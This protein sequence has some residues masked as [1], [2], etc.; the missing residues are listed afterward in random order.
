MILVLLHLYARTVIFFLVFFVYTYP[1][2]AALLTLPGFPH[3]EI[4]T[5]DET[6]TNKQGILI[7]TWITCGNAT[8]TEFY[9]L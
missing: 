9:A 6:D 2:I 5:W 1:N 7:L 4:E 3:R 8:T